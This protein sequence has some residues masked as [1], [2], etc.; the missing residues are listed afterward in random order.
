[1]LPATS[2]DNEGD[3]RERYPKALRERSLLHAISRERSDLK[4]LTFGQFGGAI[5]LTKSVSS[6]SASKGTRWKNSHSQHP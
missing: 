6:L 4:N 1:M 3:V 5:S 2:R